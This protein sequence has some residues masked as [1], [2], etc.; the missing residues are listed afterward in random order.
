MH[1]QFL[2]SSLA[3]NFSQWPLWSQWLCVPPLMQAPLPQVHANAGCD[4]RSVLYRITACG[5]LPCT[6]ASQALWPKLKGLKWMHS[7]MA[8]VEPLLSISELVQGPVIL[9]NAKGEAS[10]IWAYSWHLCFRA[11]DESELLTSLLRSQ[12]CCLV[13]AFFVWDQ[14]SQ[15]LRKRARAKAAM[16]DNFPRMH[17]STTG[18]FSSA[19]AHESSFVQIW[20]RKLCSWECVSSMP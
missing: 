19:C 15:V 6:V 20:G 1:C 18:V 5:H 4:A 3:D 7:A 14:K 17:R 2:S 9:T 8:G 11:H 16:A 12:V 10:C 13:L